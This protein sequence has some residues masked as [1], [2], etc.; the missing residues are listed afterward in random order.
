MPENKKIADTKIA[1]AAAAA[2]TRDWASLHEDL[3]SLIGWRVLA[4]DL[5]DY[6]RFRAACPH[7]RSSAACPR[8]R[9]V[10][11]PRFHRRRWMLF[12][13]GHGLHPGHVDLGGRVRFFNLSTGAFVRARLPLFSDHC[14]LDSVDGV[15]LQ[16]DRDTA[17][18]L[19]HPFT[20]DVAEFP[21]LG[22]QVGLSQRYPRRLHQRGCRWSR[23]GDDVP[24][25]HQELLLCY[26]WGSA[27]EDLKLVARHVLVCSIAVPRKDLH[28][29]SS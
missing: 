1:A 19:L 18:R 23:H 22:K 17:V 5:R 3:V 6:V 16:R 10:P 9:G 25:R 8:G 14:V 21:P 24:T 13:E 27:M 2:A 12:P 29:A 20:G 11:D 7:W 28:V 15:L 26:L 4:G